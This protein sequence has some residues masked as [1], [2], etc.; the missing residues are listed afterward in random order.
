MAPPQ[1]LC[2]AED[3]EDI[4]A[5]SQAQAERV[6][7]MAE[8]SEA[9]SPEEDRGMGGARGGAMGGGRTPTTS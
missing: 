8:F 1:A 6:A 3:P 2:G 7:A 4:R 9:P 5:A